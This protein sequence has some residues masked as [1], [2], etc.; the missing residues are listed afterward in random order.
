[1]VIQPKIC[2]ITIFLQK[3]QLR[4]F[5]PLNLQTTENARENKKYGGKAKT[6]SYIL[7]LRSKISTY[8]CLS[9]LLFKTQDCITE[10]NR[11]CKAVSSKTRMHA[12]T[13]IL[14]MVLSTLYFTDVYCTCRPF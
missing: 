4:I 7:S 12:T 1:M 6:A 8:Q 9:S 3:Q 2:S 11:D 5:K 10:H 13:E 14:Y